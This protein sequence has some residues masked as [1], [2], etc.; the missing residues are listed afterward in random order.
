MFDNN[1]D[2]YIDHEEIKRTMHFLGEEVTDEDVRAMIQEADSDKD[3][4]V[5]FDDQR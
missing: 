5:N 3:G 2:S 1:N 4:L